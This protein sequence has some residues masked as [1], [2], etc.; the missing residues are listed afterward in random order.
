MLDD[1]VSGGTLAAG[2]ITHPRTPGEALV[3]GTPEAGITGDLAANW[4][5]VT[6]TCGVPPETDADGAVFHLDGRVDLNA[7][8]DCEPTMNGK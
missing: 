3:S 7:H 6:L 4:G 2:A 5:T 1:A 8:D